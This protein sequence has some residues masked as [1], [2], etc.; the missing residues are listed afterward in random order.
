[1][2][3]GP[4]QAVHLQLVG[5]LELDHASVG[6]R[7]EV[8]VHDQ[9]QEPA[10]MEVQNILDGAYIRALAPLADQPAHDK[11]SSRLGAGLDGQFHAVAMCPLPERQANRTGQAL[12]GYGYPLSHYIRNREPNRTA[13]NAV[14]GICLVVVAK[15][16]PSG[17]R[18]PPEGRSG[19]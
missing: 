5:F 15:P 7:S 6:L 9:W 13:N 4:D 16:H 12:G 1:E 8:A 10:N 19:G 18:Q 3:L 14:S 2:R 17:G 11:P